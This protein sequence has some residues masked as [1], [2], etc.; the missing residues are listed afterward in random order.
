MNERTPSIGRKAQ[1]VCAHYYGGCIIH[2]LAPDDLKDIKSLLTG[3]QMA[4]PGAAQVQKHGFTGAGV[5][6]TH[7][8]AQNLSVQ[9]CRLFKTIRSD[10]LRTWSVS[11]SKEFFMY[12]YASRCAVPTNLREAPSPNLTANCLM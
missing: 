2:L 8:G 9:R 10:G 12:N 1:D 6:T 11:A 5:V 3:R 7:Q 4:R